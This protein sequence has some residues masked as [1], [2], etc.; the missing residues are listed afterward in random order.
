[1][2]QEEAENGNEMPDLSMPVR[3]VK[4]AADNLIKV[5]LKLKGYTKIKMKFIHKG[6]L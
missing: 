3:I 1:V 6:C 5:K 2:L 4:L